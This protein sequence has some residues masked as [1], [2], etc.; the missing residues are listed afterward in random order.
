[1]RYMV[2]VSLLTFILPII[3]SIIEILLCKNSFFSFNLFS[4]WF[5]FS[6]VGLRLFLAGIKQIVDPAFTAK[7]IFH[8]DNFDSFPILRELGF[9]NF[10]FGLIGIISLFLPDWRMVSAF[11]SGLYYGIAGFQHLLKKL[12]GTNEKFALVTDLVIFV[13]MMCYFLKMM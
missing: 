1:M 9:A 11:G 7:E 2:G 13:L 3:F 10:C 4:K 6:A 12:K 5:T 8:L